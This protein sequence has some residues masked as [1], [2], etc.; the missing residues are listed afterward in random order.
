MISV[1]SET[2]LLFP[3]QYFISKLLLGLVLILVTFCWSKNYVYC[4]VGGVDHF[5]FLVYLVLI[6]G[7]P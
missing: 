5:L 1:R 4:L 6:R 2:V 7:N 3:G